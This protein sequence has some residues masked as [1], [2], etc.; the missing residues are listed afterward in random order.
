M[1][2]LLLISSFHLQ[3]FATFSLPPPSRR[4][5]GAR[6]NTCCVPVSAL[7]VAAQVMEVS[8]L[9]PLWLSRGLGRERGAGRSWR[10]V[11]GSPRGWGKG[12]R[13]GSLLGWGWVEGRSSGAFRL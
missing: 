5:L 13:G 9:L 4:L 2:G 8:R 6:L 7:K 10:D 12:L 11:V 3:T 1:S